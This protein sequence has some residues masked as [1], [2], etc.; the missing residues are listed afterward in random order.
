MPTACWGCVDVELA[1]DQEGGWDS[2]R[3]GASRFREGRL[4]F[5]AGRLVGIE[6]LLG[7]TK[8]WR[9]VLQVHAD[10]RPGVKSSPHGIDENVRRFEV[11]ACLG[12]A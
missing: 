12:V 7:R 4:R 2:S 11:R 5:P 1:A 8:D 3:K 6:R 10:P 9:N